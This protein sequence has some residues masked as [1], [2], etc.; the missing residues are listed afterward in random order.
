MCSCGRHCRVLCTTITQ[1]SSVRNLT[2]FL[3]VLWVSLL[4]DHFMLFRLVP[5]KSGSFS[6]MCWTEQWEETRFSSDT[7]SE[8]VSLVWENFLSFSIFLCDLI[9]HHV[10]ARYWRGQICAP[11]IAGFASSLFASLLFSDDC[12]DEFQHCFWPES[13][14]ILYGSEAEIIAMKLWWL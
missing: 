1:C 9:W 8:W 10:G 11:T 4:L 3:L 2:K 6:K 14:P 5:G 12:H 7:V 13:Y